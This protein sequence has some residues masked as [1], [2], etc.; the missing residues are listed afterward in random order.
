MRFRLCLGDRWSLGV[1]YRIFGQ[2][3]ALKFEPKN[4]NDYF[5]Q[6]VQQLEEVDPFQAAV[7][8]FEWGKYLADQKEFEAA[9]KL[10]QQAHSE[11]EKFTGSPEL[12]QTT[13]FLQELTKNP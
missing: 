11:F 7:T 12:V 2:I 3:H 1:N 8:R 9:T 13:I 5:A 4:A 10:I 6:S